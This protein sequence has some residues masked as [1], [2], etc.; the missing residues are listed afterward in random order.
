LEECPATRD[1]V[2][3]GEVSLTQA[4]EI[5]AAE[6]VVRGSEVSLPEV[7]TSSGMAGLR[8]ASRKVRLDAFDRDELHRRQRAARTHR[9]WID[10]DGM[11][12][13][14]YRLSPEVDVP[15]VN[16]PRR[17]DRPGP[18]RRTPRGQHR[19][20]RRARRRRTAAHER[21]WREGQGESRRRG[22]RVL[23]RRVPTRTPHADEL[24]HVIGS[25][26]VPV[27]VVREAVVDDAFVKAVM[28]RGD[29]IHTVAHFG[30]RTSATLRTALELGPA[31][32]FEGEV[33]A[34]EGC[35]RRHDLERDHVD[36]VA[37]DGLTSYANVK[38]RCRPHHW[39]KTERDRQAGLLSGR[40]LE[41]GPP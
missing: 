39:A 24:C 27:A 18:S 34:E 1:A 37:N 21:S 8:E 10:G 5:V 38:A 26:P 23:P 32:T 13:G 31:P 6:A 2:R 7:A 12:A 9:H 28:M 36:P 20:A 30:R 11:V 3:D 4:K 14:Q 19:S 15:F 41:R 35:D 29:E 17:R 25:G 16:A 40:G 22:V 33:C